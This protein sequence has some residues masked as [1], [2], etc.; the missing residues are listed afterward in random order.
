MLTNVQE[1]DDINRLTFYIM[2]SLILCP[3]AKTAYLA[4]VGILF[5]EKFHFSVKCI[6]P[7]A[8]K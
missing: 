8:R 4:I 3:L 7:K 2:L 1:Y 5:D 6:D